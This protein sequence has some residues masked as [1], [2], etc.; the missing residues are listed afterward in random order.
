[1]RILFYL[2]L[3]IQKKRDV[4]KRQ[5]YIYIRGEYVY[6]REILEAAIKQAYEAK[7]IG[8]NNKHGCDFDLHVSHGAVAYIC[9]EETAQIESLEGKKG[10]PRLKPPFL[11]LI[12]I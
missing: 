8:K 10:Q 12:H 6:E 5:A 1:M 4:Y 3:L 7:L 11:S 2:P 9:G